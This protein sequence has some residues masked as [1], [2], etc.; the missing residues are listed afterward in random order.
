MGG[1]GLSL[2]T[3]SP[4]RINYSDVSICQRVPA[5]RLGDRDLPPDGEGDGG[6]GANGRIRGERDGET[7][8]RMDGGGGR[9]DEKG[10]PGVSC[11][12]S[13]SN[14]SPLPPHSCPPLI[15]PSSSL[16]HLPPLFVFSHFISCPPPIHHS[17]SPSEPPDR[18]RLHLHPR[19]YMRS[20][21]EETRL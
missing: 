14:S 5:A 19:P 17:S 10:A 3:L 7:G 2:N 21:W 1:G 6:G 20:F 11:T 18:D 16:L 8:R 9:R 12:A 15:P 13:F 4:D